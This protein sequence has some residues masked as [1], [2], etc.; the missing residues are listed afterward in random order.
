MATEEGGDGNPVMPVFGPTMGWEIWH[1]GGRALRPSQLG[2]GS[3]KKGCDGFVA[4]RVHSG[5]E[6][7][8]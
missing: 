5:G 3:P 8:C 7:C 6:G 4:C 1:M 2:M